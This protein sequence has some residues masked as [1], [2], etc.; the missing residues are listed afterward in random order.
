M[1]LLLAYFYV[2]SVP[3][4]V[5]SAYSVN[6]NKSTKNH[7]TNQQND[8]NPFFTALTTTTTTANDNVKEGRRSFVT[9]TAFALSSLPFFPTSS[10]NAADDAPT[11]LYEDK[12]NKFSIQVPSEW[13][14]SEQ[15]LADRR[16]IVLFLDPNDKETLMFIAYTPIRDDFTSLGSFGSV[17]SVGQMTVLP[18]GTIGLQESESKMLKAESKKNA[19]FFDYKQKVED[20]PETH[21]RSIFTLT[22]QEKQGGSGSNLITISIQTPEDRYTDSKNKPI[23]DQLMNAYKEVK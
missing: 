12:V 3:K 13:T 16:R 9:K 20:R 8:N 4:G 15:E 18:K 14:K 1:L 7:A 10:V 19:Y 5:V 22:S 2:G 6:N 11:T 21:F 17:E 23:F